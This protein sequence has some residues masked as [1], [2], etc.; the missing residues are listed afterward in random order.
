MEDRHY[1][2]DR[3]EVDGREY[4]FYGV[5]D[6]HGGK[7]ASDYAAEHMFEV[8]KQELVNPERRCMKDVLLWTHLRVDGEFIAHE[9][10]DASGTTSVVVVIELSATPMKWHCAWAGDSRAVLVRSDGAVE[11]VSRDHKA[12]RPDEVK[13]VHAAGGFVMCGRVMG[14]LAVSR[15]LGDAEFKVKDVP[16]QKQI[17]TAEP[18]YDSGT[19]SNHAFFV[20]ACDGLYD[21]MTDSR[22]AEIT[23]R[24][25]ADCKTYPRT[26]PADLAAVCTATVKLA[27]E[28]LYTR[29]N[30][31][32]IVVRLS[33]APFSVLSPTPPPSPA[34]PPAADTAPTM[35]TT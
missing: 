6:G 11:W 32:A 5:F 4:A 22:V 28:T 18:E 25:I 16:W 27:I 29:D 10:S 31:T 14:D 20:V 35:P 23:G 24:A 8:L 19:L 12:D 34:D 13:R 9:D 1:A 21:V 2:N 7:K 17:V 3:F 15:A 33:D 26:T 30:V